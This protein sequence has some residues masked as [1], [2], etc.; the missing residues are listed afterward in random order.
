MSAAGVAPRRGAWI[1]IQPLGQWLWENFLVAPRRG[2]WIEII[3]P[4]GKTLNLP[5]AP[6][7]GAWI[8]IAL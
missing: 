2:A 6:R 3:V 1:E 7:R 8:E 4:S 5:V